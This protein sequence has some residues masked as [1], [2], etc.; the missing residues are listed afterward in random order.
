MHDRPHSALT[1]CPAGS[2]CA[3]GVSTASG[4]LWACLP[5]VTLANHTHASKLWTCVSGAVASVRHRWLL[6]PGWHDERYAVPVSRWLLL[7]R[8]NHVW[9]SEPVPCGLLL[10]GGNGHV[11]RQPLHSWLLLPCG[12]VERDRQRVP[13]GLL[14]LGRGQQRHHQRMP[15]RHLEQLHRPDGAGFMHVVHCRHLQLD[16]RV[17]VKHL[18]V[19]PAW[20]IQLHGGDDV[21]HLSLVQHQRL[22]RIVVQ[23][24]CRLPR[25]PLQRHDTELHR[26][27][28]SLGE[29]TRAQWTAAGAG[30]G[31]RVRA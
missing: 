16:H 22:W 19:V 18:P 3:A 24:L 21:H 28:P 7:P 12:R 17:D 13:S 11:D 15:G 4:K 8:R 23:L 10:P 14:L 1:E 31:G 20:R 27:V 2:F 26:C 5:F 9:H 29:R 30:A 25:H 6:L